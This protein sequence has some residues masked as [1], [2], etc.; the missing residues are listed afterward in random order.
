MAATKA[1][2]AETNTTW[3]HGKLK[4]TLTRKS[5]NGGAEERKVT[6]V[7]KEGATRSP[8]SDGF[9][10]S[11]SVEAF[12]EFSSSIGALFCEVDRD[13]F[14]PRVEGDCSCPTQHALDC[15]K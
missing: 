1:T 7:N 10:W 3:E 4:L 6:V 11:G 14:G 12:K 9:M 13:L 2:I 15:P 8:S 5:I